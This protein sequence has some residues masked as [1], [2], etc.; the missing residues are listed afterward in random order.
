MPRLCGAP[1]VALHI[2]FQ[3][4]RVVYQSVHR[5]QRHGRLHRHLTPLRERCVG[6][7]SQAL[8]LIPFGYQFEQHGSLCLVAPHVTE[9]IQNQQVK[10][11]QLG[12]TLWQA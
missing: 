8:A 9:V 2:H 12:Q 3:N 5:C 11:V 10:P 4:R 1:V 6:G 7:D